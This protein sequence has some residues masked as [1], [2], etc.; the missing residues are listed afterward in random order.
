MAVTVCTFNVNSIR[1]RIDLIE[2]WLN[3]K[4]EVDILCFQE[5]KCEAEQFPTGRFEALGYHCAVNGQKRL[6][7]VAVCSKLPIEDVKTAFG[8]DVLDREKRLLECRIAETVLL[9]CYIPRGGLEG[10]ERHRYKMEFFDALTRYTAALLKEYQ[11]VILLGDF[12]VALEEIDVYDPEVF[13]G[14]VGFLPSEKEKM[15]TLLQTGLVDCYRA[16]H[17]KEKGFTWWD[18]RGGGIWRDEGMRIDYLLA[19]ETGCDNLEAIDIDLW[20]RRRRSPTPSDHAPIVATF[21]TL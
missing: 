10:E 14:A 13:E 18:Y 12:N 19:S 9:N 20:T 4:R 2:R 8:I 3:E 5:I 7:G 15:R 17:P 1:S 11:K 6:N 21:G 16:R